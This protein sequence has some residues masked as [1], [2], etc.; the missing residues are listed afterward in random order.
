MGGLVFE[1]TTP[2]F[3]NTHWNAT[4]K[5]LAESAFSFI[6]GII[7]YNVSNYQNFGNWGVTQ[8][9]LQQWLLIKPQLFKLKQ[10]VINAQNLTE[11]QDDLFDFAFIF[12]KSWQKEMSKNFLK[13]KLGFSQMISDLI[14]WI[15]KNMQK[16]RSLY[17]LG[18]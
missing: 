17:I 4:S 10:K 5:Y 16:Y 18:V 11:Q 7:Y 9:T 6:E 8:V 2:P 3:K 1:F 15:D 12:D 13:Y 14:I